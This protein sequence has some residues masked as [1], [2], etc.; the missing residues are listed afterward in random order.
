MSYFFE[1]SNVDHTS[2]SF[3]GFQ[4]DFKVDKIILKYDDKEEIYDS[5]SVTIDGNKHVINNLTDI[6]IY[7][8]DGE[9]PVIEYQ[10]IY[11]SNKHIHTGGLVTLATDYSLHHS[12]DNDYNFNNGEMLIYAVAEMPLVATNDVI[13]TAR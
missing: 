3:D 12:D 5:S 8:V 10:G 4:F 1:Y 7:K 2:E 13:A 11:K 6:N 9:F